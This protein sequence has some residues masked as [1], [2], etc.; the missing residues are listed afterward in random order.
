MQH[1]MA[2]SPAKD[3]ASIINGSTREAKVLAMPDVR[4]S[5]QQGTTSTGTPEQFGA[6]SSP[7][8]RVG[9]A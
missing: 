1:G 6:Y 9:K 8:S 3:A 7:R 2:A 5:S 4:I